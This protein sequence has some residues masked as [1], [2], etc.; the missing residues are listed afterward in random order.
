MLP[1]P[2]QDGRCVLWETNSRCSV[3]SNLG[4]N[5]PEVLA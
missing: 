2:F 5:V 3:S 1:L 4:H